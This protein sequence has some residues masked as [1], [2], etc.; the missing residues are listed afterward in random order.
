[1]NKG[2]KKTII[3][4]AGGLVAMALVFT[5][6]CKQKQE[7]LEKATLRINC[8]AGYAKPYE[9]DFKALVKEKY[10]IDIELSIENPTDQD[11]FFLAV[12]KQHRRPDLASH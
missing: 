9:A 10:N 1:M 7:K 6:G 3:T 5:P 8:W 12:K 11:E 2:L 4:I